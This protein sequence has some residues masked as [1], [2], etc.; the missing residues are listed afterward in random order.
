MATINLASI[1]QKCK[2]WSETPEGK[3]RMKAVVDRLVADGATTTAA[4]GRILSETD[5]YTAAAKLIGVLQSTAQSYGLPASIMRHFDSISCSEVKK[6]PDGSSCIFV[7][8]GEDLH[9]DSLYSD[10]YDGVDNIIAV[11]N[12]GYHA[13]NY[14]YGDWDGHA[15]TGESVLDGRSIDTSA[16]IRSRKDREGLGFIQ[17]AVQDF[18]NN[19]GSDFDV[20]AVAGEEYGA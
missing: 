20:T 2:E 7:Y 17:Q 16:F 18:N 15:P 8:F 14:V 6:M 19:Y 4:G 13:S 11:L 1:S 12:N 5:M 3:R 10:G 9:R